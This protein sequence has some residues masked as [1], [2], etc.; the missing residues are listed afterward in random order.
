[1]ALWPMNSNSMLGAFG[2]TEDRAIVVK[3][4]LVRGLQSAM[5]S[6]ILQNCYELQARS[7]WA[8]EGRGG[9]QART[10][11]MLHAILME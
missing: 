4:R 10:Y 6:R 9:V 2:T 8:C 11:H 7:P 3:A 1:M 5:T